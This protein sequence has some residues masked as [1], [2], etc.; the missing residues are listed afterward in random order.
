MKQEEEVMEKI[1]ARGFAKTFL[2]DLHESVFENLV[3]TGQC[4]SH[5]SLSLHSHSHSRAL[6]IVIR[7]GAS[8]VWHLRGPFVRCEKQHQKHKGVWVLW[9]V[10][11]CVW[12]GAQTPRVRSI[13]CVVISS[14]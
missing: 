4:L 1:A 2:N 7:L 3:E 5:F 9:A 11:W 6:S 14:Y 12:R 10:W 13:L 8:L